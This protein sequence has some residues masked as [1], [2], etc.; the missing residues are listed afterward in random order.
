L[1]VE[2]AT[3]SKPEHLLVLPQHHHRVGESRAHLGGL[4]EVL[5]SDF[6][7]LGREQ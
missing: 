3:G 6:E 7:F 4:V 1:F 5:Y 2:S